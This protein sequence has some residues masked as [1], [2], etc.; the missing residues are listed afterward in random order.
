MELLFVL[1]FGLVFGSFVTCASYRLPRGEDVVR[2]PSHC[3]AC[4]VTLGFKDLF[5]VVS[6]LVAKGKCRHCGTRVHWRYP[7]IEIACAAAFLFIYL[8]YGLTPQGV[9]LALFAVALLIMIVVDFEHYIIPDEIHWALLPLGVAYHYFRGTPFTDAAVSMVLGAAIG[10]ALHHSYRLIRKKE[11]LGFGD[12]KFLGVAGLW[13]GSVMLFPPFLFFSGALGVLTGLFWRFLGLG[14][15]FPFGP[16]L[17][18]ALF[19]CVAIPE[20]PALFWALGQ[21]LALRLY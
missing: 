12:V 11:G 7:L 15:R 19:I 20:W 16:A 17:A 5:P 10:L 18:A 9:M 13:L 2:K 14:E 1:F 6:W 3:T 21:N 4:G 8:R